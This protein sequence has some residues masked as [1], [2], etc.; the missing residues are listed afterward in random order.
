M[1][2]ILSASGAGNNGFLYSSTWVP[3]DYSNLLYWLDAQDLTTL[4]QNSAL[5]TP[6]AA[7]NDPVGGWKDKSGNGFHLTQATNGFR[8][9]YKTSGI[10]GLPAVLSDG[11]DDFLRNTNATTYSGPFTVY[12]ILKPADVS[13]AHPFLDSAI[14]G[15]TG[16]TILQIAAG[17][18]WRCSAG[19]NL[20][21][22]LVPTV[23]PHLIVATY[24]SASSEQNVDGAITAQGTTG[25]NGWKPITMFAN[26]SSTPTVWGSHYAGEVMVYNALHTLLQKRQVGMYLLK[27]W[28]LTL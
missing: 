24:N 15:T 23:A 27:K 25:T 18:V 22:V 5:S 1:P 19:S 12:A 10:N 28:L 13:R 7:N 26:Q 20:D 14:Q 21:S 16:R 8:P 11:T 6:V 9:L 3:T 4:F 2:G 17:P